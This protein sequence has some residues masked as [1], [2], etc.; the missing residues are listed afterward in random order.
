MLLTIF[1]F[2]C[3]IV[4]SFRFDALILLPAMLLGWVLAVIGGLV[5]GGTGLSILIG[6]VLVACALQ[7]GYIGGIVIQWVS[8]VMRALPKRRLEKSAAAAHRAF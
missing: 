8:G 1:C 3:G 7:G 2:L 5:D 6:M 4:L